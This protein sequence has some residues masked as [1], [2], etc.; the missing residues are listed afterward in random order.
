MIAFLL[1][2]IGA[3]LLVVALVTEMIQYGIASMTA[4]LIGMATVIVRMVVERRA[5]DEEHAPVEQIEADDAAEGVDD[6]GFPATSAVEG[7]RS[8]EESQPEEEAPSGST[9]DVAP[10]LGQ[11]D[12]GSDDTIRVIPGRKRFHH[13][14]CASLAGRES[15]ELTREEAEEEGFTPCSICHSTTQ[16]AKRAV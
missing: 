5:D 11:H 15:E 7:S 6:A 9:V 3:G 16:T 14:D 1:V 2:I 8:G 13:P 4:V 10:Q 12:I